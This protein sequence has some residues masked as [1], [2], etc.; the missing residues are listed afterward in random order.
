MQE[1]RLTFLAALAM[2]LHSA[3]ALF[4]YINLEPRPGGRK[5][6]TSRRRRRHQEPA[7]FPRRASAAGKRGV[8][9]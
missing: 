5:L 4:K 3:V 8:N 2:P 9:A 1:R 7:P 6:K